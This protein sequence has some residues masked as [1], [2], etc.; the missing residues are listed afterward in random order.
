MA[1]LGY[2]YECDRCRERITAP[3][4]IFEKSLCPR[5]APDGKRCL[6]HLRLIEAQPADGDATA[7]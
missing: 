7:V 1:D 4:P 6:G 3:R 5:P 2:V